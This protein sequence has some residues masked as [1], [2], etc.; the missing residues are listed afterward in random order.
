MIE[1]YIFQIE[2]DILLILVLVRFCNCSVKFVFF[3]FFLIVHLSYQLLILQIIF[4]LY[5]LSFVMSF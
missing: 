2:I 1:K 4:D 3:C 5:I